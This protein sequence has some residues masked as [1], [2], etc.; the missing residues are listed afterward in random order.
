MEVVIFIL[1]A[2]ALVHAY[3]VRS[4]ARVLAPG[5]IL[6][7]YGMPVDDDSLDAVARSVNAMGFEFQFSEDH[8]LVSLHY[9]EASDVY[10]TEIKST[11]PTDHIL[12][13]VLLVTLRMFA[14]QHPE[15]TCLKDY[16]F[17]W[18]G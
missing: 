12:A 14:A 1:G 11:N 10:A 4:Q 7:F 18:R 8:Q 16:P 5:F 13:G 15:F 9:K 17:L 2:C 3:R 6:S